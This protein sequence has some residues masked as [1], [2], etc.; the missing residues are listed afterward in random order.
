MDPPATLWHPKTSLSGDSNTKHVVAILANI[1]VAYCLQLQA[2][3]LIYLNS[4]ELIGSKY[5]SMFQSLEFF[6]AVRSHKSEHK[7]ISVKA[8]QVHISPASRADPG[9][10]A[11]TRGNATLPFFWVPELSPCLSYSESRLTL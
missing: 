2:H 8:S 7:E 1:F 3:V 11:S 4:D 5:E 6:C 9:L 10:L